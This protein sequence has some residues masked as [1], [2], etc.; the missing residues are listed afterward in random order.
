F[1]IV[2]GALIQIIM[3]SRIIYGMSFKG[4]LPKIF[5]L[6]NKRTKTPIVATI[7]VTSITL[8][9]ALWF[10]LVGLANMTSTLILI[11]FTI[12]NISL[13]RIKLK[14]PKPENVFTIPLLVPIIATILN[15]LFLGIEFF[16]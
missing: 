10:P 8:V 12:V 5:R 14:H 16:S 1:A 9:L 4:W 2:N 15:T 11:I 3:A 13:I 7:F 6:V